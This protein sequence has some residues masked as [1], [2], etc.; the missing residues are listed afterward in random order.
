MATVSSGQVFGGGPYSKKTMDQFGNNLIINN[1]MADTYTV[2][3]AQPRCLNVTA[4]LD[5]TITMTGDYTMQPLTLHCGNALWSDNIIDVSDVGIVGGQW[6]MSQEDLKPGDTL[7]GDVNFD[8][9][10][11]IRDL[12]LV[13]GNYSLISE[14]AYTNWTP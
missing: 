10:V 1:V 3:T 6:G 5:K 14:D 8:N 11:N 7:N 2:T 4:E 12:A 13:A 9:I